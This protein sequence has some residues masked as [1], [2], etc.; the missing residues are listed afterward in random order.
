MSLIPGSRRYLSNQ[1]TV[2][3]L[4]QALYYGLSFGLGAAAASW[5][6][7]DPCLIAL[8]VNR[9]ANTRRG[10]CRDLPLRQSQAQFPIKAGEIMPFVMPTL[11]LSPDTLRQ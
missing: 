6:V 10:I 4:S 9:H 1:T 5:W 3:V 11:I 7:L 2:S 8:H